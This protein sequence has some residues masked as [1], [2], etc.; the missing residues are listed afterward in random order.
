MQ[1]NNYACDDETWTC[2]CE[3]HPVGTDSP[4]EGQSAKEQAAMANY[5]S[6]PWGSGWKDSGCRDEDLPCWKVFDKQAKWLEVK[7]Y[8]KG[9][10]PKGLDSWGELD[11]KWYRRVLDDIYNSPEKFTTELREDAL[12]FVYDLEWQNSYGEDVN[13]KEM[14]SWP[15][16]YGD[17]EKE[18]LKRDENWRKDSGDKESWVIHKNNK[19]NPLMVLFMMSLM[20]IPTD[21]TIDK[22]DDWPFTTDDWNKSDDDKEKWDDKEKEDDKEKKDDEDHWDDKEQ[23]GGE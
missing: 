23:W 20:T 1:K 11:R 5:V 19:E 17:F 10:K 2:T 8:E 15:R 4:C 3:G 6:A 22:V 16:Y 14:D 12:K 21:I 13:F 7:E 18:R 9:Y